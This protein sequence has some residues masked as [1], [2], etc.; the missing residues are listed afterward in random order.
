M[1]EKSACFDTG[2]PVRVKSARYVCQR[3]YALFR[4]PYGDKIIFK[5]DAYLGNVD[6]FLMKAHNC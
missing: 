5:N 6:V 3:T 2:R 1:T 4:K